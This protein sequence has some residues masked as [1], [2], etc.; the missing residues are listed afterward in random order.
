[1]SA[2]DILYFLIAENR[3]FRSKGQVVSKYAIF[4]FVILLTV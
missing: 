4:D 2:G 1:M 3:V